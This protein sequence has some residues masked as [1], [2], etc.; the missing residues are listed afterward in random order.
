MRPL[1]NSPAI[2]RIDWSPALRGPVHPPAPGARAPGRPL[3]LSA[4]EPARP[5]AAERAAPDV[6]V[7][8]RVGRDGSQIT[9]VRH[10]RDDDGAPHTVGIEAV[11]R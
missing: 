4:A 7:S 2:D 6:E 5:A 8:V 10:V 11:I 3:A 1:P 9:V